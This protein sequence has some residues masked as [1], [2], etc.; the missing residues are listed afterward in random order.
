MS[1]SFYSVVLNFQDFRIFT[2]N[3]L[4]VQLTK[5]LSEMQRSEHTIHES[6]RLI[7]SGEQMDIVFSPFFHAVI[8][9]T[10]T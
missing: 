7:S 5:K 8:G 2:T 4:I 3:L 10:Y 1:N 9:K 6:I